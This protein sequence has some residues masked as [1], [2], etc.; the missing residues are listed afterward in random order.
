MHVAYLSLVTNLLISR[1]Q[2][3][4][5]KSYILLERQFIINLLQ[6]MVTLLF[7]IKSSVENF[8]FD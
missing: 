8:I 7:A 5:G 4:I 2:S 3:K 1:V 6:I